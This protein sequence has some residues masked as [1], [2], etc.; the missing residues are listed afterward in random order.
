MILDH[1][2]RTLELEWRESGVAQPP[3]AAGRGYGR[4]L[5][6]VALPF[7]LGATPQFE[8]LP[9]GIY[10]SIQLPDHEWQRQALSHSSPFFVT[11]PPS[12]KGY[13]WKQALL[14][15]RR[16]IQPKRRAAALRADAIGL[17]FADTS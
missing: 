5:I 16:L 1:Q 7:A 6:E 8:F 2:A 10:C 15:N 14:N 13:N 17:G 11:A 4:E 12:S 9:D 3:S